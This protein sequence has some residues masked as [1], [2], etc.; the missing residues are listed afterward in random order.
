MK[1]VSYNLFLS[2]VSGICNIIF[3]YIL[4]KRM[5][6]VGAAYATL[7]VVVVASILSFG[8]LMVIMR[9]KNYG[10]Y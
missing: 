2:I 1:R 8:Y 9:R 6:A 5:G 4:V 7:G 10:D 3:D